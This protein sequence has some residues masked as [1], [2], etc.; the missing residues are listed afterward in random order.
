MRIGEMRIDNSRTPAFRKKPHA[1][2]GFSLVELMVGMAIA[3]I[4]F[5]VISG[6]FINFDNQK[7]VTSLSSDTQSSG[8]MAIFELEQAIRSAGAGIVS[9]DSFDCAPANTKSYYHRLGPPEVTLDPVPGY[10]QFFAPVVITNGAGNASDT[11]ELRVGAPVANAAP[12]EL[13][14]D[15]RKTGPTPEEIKVQ[16]GTG[17]SVGSVLMVV[18]STI[19]A[20]TVMEVTSVP[21]SDSPNRMSIAPAASG[22]TWNPTVA[23]RTT[24]NWPDFPKEGSYVYAPGIGSDGGMFFRTYTVN[25][26]GQLEVLNSKAEI[27]SSTEVLV[28]DVVRFHAQYGVSSAVGVQ[29]IQKWVEPVLGGTYETNWDVGSLDAN[30]VKRIKAVRLVIVLRSPKLEAGNVTNTCTNNAGVNNGP[31]AWDDT[32]V[33]PAPLIDLSADANWRRYRYRVFQTIVPLRN[34]IAAGV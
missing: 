8:I 10:G 2:R 6:V 32:V 22:N 25:A 4:M 24:N 13:A 29:D 11:L 26:S 27:A 15:I 12:T 30:K 18:N 21:D 17:F 28:G 34:T 19:P 3:M 1:L 14:A 20:C 33:D 7:R 9:E 23:Y 5:L 16:R 31:C